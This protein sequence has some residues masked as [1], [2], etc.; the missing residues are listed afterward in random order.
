MSQCS[1]LRDKISILLQQLVPH[2]FPLS[3]QTIEN[4]GL[5]HTGGGWW[6]YRGGGDLPQKWVGLCLC[7]CLC[8]WDIESLTLAPTALC[9]KIH[10]QG[11]CPNLLAKS[12]SRSSIGHLNY[13]WLRQS[14]KEG[15]NALTYSLPGL[16]SMVG[17][18][19]RS[20][21]ESTWPATATLPQP[22]LPS[23]SHSSFHWNCWQNADDKASF[24]FL[25]HLYDPLGIKCHFLS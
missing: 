18:R 5:M 23:L 15:R 12:T 21:A 2:T 4:Q 14:I 6:T 7:L 3:P 25:I 16:A 20:V 9:H 24:N 17:C 8:L 11:P 10:P 13:T 22:Q 19:H 1:C